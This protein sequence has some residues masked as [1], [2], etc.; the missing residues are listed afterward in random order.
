MPRTFNLLVASFAI[1]AAFVVAIPKPVAA[2]QGHGTDVDSGGDLRG[3]EIPPA[4]NPAQ[5]WGEIQAK[6]DIIEKLVQEEK[7]AEIHAATEGL[8]A[9]GAKLLSVSTAL[10]ESKRA[11]VEGAVNQLPNVADRLHDAADA[12][13]AEKT[14]AEFKKLDGLLQLIAAQ[15]PPG[16]LKTGGA[17]Q[18]HRIRHEETAEG[19]K[20]AH[21]ESSG[22]EPAEI[23]KNAQIVSV[24]AYDLRFD[25]AEVVVQRSVPVALTLINRGKTEHAW[26]I[27]SK[28]EVHLHAMVEESDTKV[29]TLEEPG[30]YPIQCTLPGHTELGMVGKLIV[31]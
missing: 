31:K 28:P 7:L 10:E 6:R 3:A 5:V 14:A 19:S 15:Y 27:E 16:V 20:H 30:E 25:P 21:H 12:G 23:P 13:K 4:E 11:R 18:S 8:A 2:T 26:V 22:G 17:S 29:F 9:L 24:S 1:A